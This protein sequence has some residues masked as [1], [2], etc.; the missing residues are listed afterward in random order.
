MERWIAVALTIETGEM[1][2]LGNAGASQE[3]ARNYTSKLPDP[4]PGV[5][6][7]VMPFD[8]IKTSD[9][10]YHTDK[11]V[12]KGPAWLKRNRDAAAIEEAKP[13]LLK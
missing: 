11:L 4:V 1:K 8:L 10:N 9:Y 13:K 2:S 12:G 3:I 7:G 5:W 6:L